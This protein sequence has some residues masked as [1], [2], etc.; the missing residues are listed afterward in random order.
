MFTLRS[1]VRKDAICLDT[2]DLSFVLFID[3]KD[4]F[5]VMIPLNLHDEEKFIRKAYWA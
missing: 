3:F 4:F 2:S 5:V 1:V